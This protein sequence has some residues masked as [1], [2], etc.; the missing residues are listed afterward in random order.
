MPTSPEALVEDCFRPSSHRSV[1]GWKGE[2]HYAEAGGL[3]DKKAQQGA[4]KQ[5]IL[6]YQKVLS[7][8]KANKADGALFKIGLAFEA[9]AYFSEAK[10]FY[11]EILAKHP[12]SPLAKEAKKRLKVVKRLAKKKGRR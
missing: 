7:L 6:S 1:C 4:Y 9:L 5:A 8:P 12:K 2:A 10:V 3:T 11:E